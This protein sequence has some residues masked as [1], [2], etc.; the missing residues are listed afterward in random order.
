MKIAVYESFFKDGEYWRE[1]EKVDPEG[2]IETLL[3]KKLLAQK[4]RE[5]LKVLDLACGHGR[6]LEQL[7]KI[8]GLK[9]YGLDINRNACAIAKKRVPSA[10][11]KMGSVYKLPYAN[12]SFD[13]VIIAAS[14][15]HFQYPLKALGE[16]C[17]V[18]RDVVF[19]DLST[20]TNISEWL[21]NLKIMGRS[22]VPE[23]R[24]DFFDIKKILPK[25][26][27]WEV[28][29]YSLLSHKLITKSLF[30]QYMRFDLYLPRTLLDKIGHSLVVIGRKKP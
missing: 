22:S 26:F 18:S 28:K 21:R 24:Y 6:L 10:N 30:R 1:W 19:F 17:R 15:M 3:L 27:E 5:G 29:G 9:L 14:F 25:G 16:I 12:N 11:I 4:K 13:V 7:S 2:G 23:K 20:K 8:K